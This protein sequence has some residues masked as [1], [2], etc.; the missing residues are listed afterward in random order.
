M[1]GMDPHVSVSI[2]KVKLGYKGIPRNDVNY[3]RLMWNIRCL[4]N[5]IT[6]SGQ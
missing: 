6:I 1:G 3:A 5:S 2:T 4:H